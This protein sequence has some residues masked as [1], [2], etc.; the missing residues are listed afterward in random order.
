MR[1]VVARWGKVLEGSARDLLAEAEAT[2]DPG[3][4]GKLDEERSKLDEAV[5]WLGELLKDGSVDSKEIPLAA[6]R[7]G[8]AWETVRRAKTRLGAKSRKQ[9]YATG[10]WWSLPEHTPQK[11]GTDEHL[12]KPTPLKPSRDAGSTEGVQPPK[13]PP[14]STPLKPSRD[15]G[16]TEGVQA[17]EENETV[18]HL[19]SNPGVA[20]VPGGREAE[21]VHAR[22]FVGDDACPKGD[23]AK[24]TAHSCTCPRCAGE[25]CRWC[26]G[27]GRLVD[28]PARG[29]AAVTLDHGP[30]SAVTALLPLPKP[31]APVPLDEALRTACEGVAGITP[32]QLR[33]LLSLKDVADIEGGCIHPKTL[34]AYSQVFA[35]G[36][37]L[38]RIVVPAA[39]HER[40]ARGPHDRRR[41]HRSGARGRRPDRLV[42]RR[43]GSDRFITRRPAGQDQGPS[44]RH[45]GGARGRGVLCIPANHEPPPHGRVVPL[46]DRARL[47][48]PM[49]GDRQAWW[50]PPVAREDLHVAC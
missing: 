49:R 16:S 47:R 27:M 24:A 30:G 40:R 6:K 42:R 37:A 41:D 44:H 17:S 34:K 50:S 31:R 38:G 12:G 20:R 13:E 33:A 3:E 18:E 8:I 28:G 32:A 21:D 15:A 14:P 48:G 45:R 29:D 19:R 4:R 5:E 35:E 22:Q 39:S 11:N 46:D 26:G 25:G 7:S 10:W 36:I 2:E 43:S 1:V 9:D 23:P